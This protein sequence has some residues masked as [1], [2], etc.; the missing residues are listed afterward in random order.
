MFEQQNMSESELSDSLCDDTKEF[1]D[2][3][4]NKLKLNFL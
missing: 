2:L 1:F 4:M 3:F